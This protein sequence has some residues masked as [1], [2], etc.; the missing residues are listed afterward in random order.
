MFGAFN[1]RWT[2]ELCTLRIVVC[3]KHVVLENVKGVHELYGN[4][5]KTIYTLY[6]VT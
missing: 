6:V 4:S 3:V 2:L 1:A 5:G